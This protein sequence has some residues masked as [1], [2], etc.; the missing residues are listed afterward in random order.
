ITTVDALAVRLLAPSLRRFRELYPEV[1]LEI[2]SSPRTLDLGRREA[3]L[4]LRMG[5]PRQETLIARKVGR[6]G[7]TLYAAESYIARR[8]LPP[9]FEGHQVVDDEEGQSVAPEVTGARSL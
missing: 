4:A 6:F 5:K 1:T 9:P 3:D 8:G 2:D 7:L